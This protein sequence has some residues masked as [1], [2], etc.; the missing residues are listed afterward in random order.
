MNLRNMMRWGWTVWLSGTVLA[1]VTSAETLETVV[2]AERPKAAVLQGE[3]AVNGISRPDLGRAL[4][5]SL[6]TELLKTGDYRVFQP[7]FQPGGGKSRDGSQQIASP[8]LQSTLGDYKLDAD[9]DYVF[10]ISVFG[11]GS[12][13]RFS[14]KKVRATNHE[15]VDAREMT[16]SGKESTLFASITTAVAQ[17]QKRAKDLNLQQ[18]QALAA[19]T[20]APPHR[21][22]MPVSQRP[23]VTSSPAPATANVAVVTS[24]PAEESPGL[25][26]YERYQREQMAAELAKVPKALI[27][28]RLG[29]IEFTND[30]WRFCVIRPQEGVKLGVNDAVHVLYDEDGK[31]YA[32][33]RISGTDSGRLIADYGRTPR[34]HPL[35]RGDAVYGWATP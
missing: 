26:E 5:D 23:T 4:A 21:V 1:T 34:H 15:V 35:F 24:A 13:Y 3:V 11:T 29:S 16:L 7:D 12:D 31:V 32:D 27:Y 33:L 19:S 9:L 18:A 6:A 10:L 25:A 28:R 8:S 2:L 20:G 30:T 14:L 17:F 22:A